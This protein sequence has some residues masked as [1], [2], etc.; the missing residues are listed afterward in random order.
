MISDAVVPESTDDG[1]TI[2]VD[3]ERGIV[4]DGDVLQSTPR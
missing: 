4:F 3:A 1:E 2:S